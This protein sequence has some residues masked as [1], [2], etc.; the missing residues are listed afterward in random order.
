MEYEWISGGTLSVSVGYCS[1][2]SDLDCWILV[3]EVDGRAVVDYE[4]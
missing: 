2:D 4:N 1:H 3:N